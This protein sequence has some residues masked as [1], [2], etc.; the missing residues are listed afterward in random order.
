[1]ETGLHYNY[2]RFYDPATGRY[3]TSDPIGFAGGLNRY[4][5]VGASPTKYI[6]PTGLFGVAD[7]PLIPQPI[8]DYFSGFGSYYSGIGNAGSHMWRRSG[9]D[10][11]CEK[12]RAIEE[13][14]ILAAGLL[15]LSNPVISAAAYGAA[16]NWAQNNKSYIAGRFT[17]GGVT[18]TIIG[19]GLYGGIGLGT[20]AAIGDALN[21]VRSGADNPEQILRAV[22]GDKSVPV[23]AGSRTKCECNR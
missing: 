10:G 14:A 23:P 21:S 5:Y 12:K 17:A 11:E 19:L 8:V 6:D 3:V 9:G 2:R 18:G 7:L 15:S 16:K 4:A 1:M 22:L 13:E 20:T